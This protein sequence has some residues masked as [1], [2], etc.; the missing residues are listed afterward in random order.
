MD[1]WINSWIDERVGDV[2]ILYD[3][4]FTQAGLEYFMTCMCLFS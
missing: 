3:I 2:N 4:L 1:E